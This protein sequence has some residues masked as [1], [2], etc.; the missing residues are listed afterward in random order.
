MAEELKFFK[1]RDCILS[2]V[3]NWMFSNVNGGYNQTAKDGS[4]WKSTD[5]TDLNNAGIGA[6]DN[7]NN[8]LSACPYLKM[9]NPVCTADTTYSYDDYTAVSVGLT[10]TATAVSGGD[11]TTIVTVSISN[12]TANDIDFSCIKFL[13]TAS[14]AYNG[15]YKGNK[16]SLIMG[17]F[18]DTPQT[19]E[20]GGGATVVLKLKAF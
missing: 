12:T 14:V 2:S 7:Y 20:A 13:Q 6:N 4:T 17:Y 5:G 15:T 19:V 1:A 16:Q 10:A 11:G 3:M 9:D 8:A 18:F